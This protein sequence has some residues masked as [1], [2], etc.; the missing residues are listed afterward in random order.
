MITGLYSAASGMIVQMKNQDVLAHN[1]GNSLIPG[2][3]RE[4]MIVRS[5]PD[6]MLEQSYAGITPSLEEPRYNHAI[7]RIGTGAGVDWVYT[8]NSPGVLQQTGDQND[9]AMV[10]DGYFTILTPDG[11]R[12]TRNGSFYR[13][14]QGYLTTPEGHYLAG[15]GG[16][17]YI[18]PIRVTS[19]EYT[20]DKY[21]NLFE[22]G[23]DPNTGVPVQNFVDQLRVVDFRNRDLLQK[24]GNNLYALEP[25]NEDQ[26]IPPRH[27]GVSQGFIERANVVPTT[28]MI[29]LMDSMR[30]FEANSRVLRKIDDTVQRAVNDVGR[31]S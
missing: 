3:K 30:T 13:D 31:V 15:Q 4:S 23:F 26:I 5:F 17:G 6:V 21:G 14:S 24:M 20:V 11:M 16:G 18:Q 8:D 12:Y 7:G 2:F 19:N 25:G 22:M 28:E 1:L 10:G 9:L 27:L 29:H